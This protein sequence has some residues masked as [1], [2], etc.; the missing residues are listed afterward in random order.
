MPTVSPIAP[1]V[2]RVR[3]WRATF[4]AAVVPIVVLIV[5]LG[6]PAAPAG[7]VAAQAAAVGGVPRHEPLSPATV[8][9][10]GV[11]AP[12][13]PQRDARRWRVS[14]DVEYGSAV[15]RNLNW[16]DAYLLDAELA[17]VQVRVRRELGARA[18]VEAQ[19]G[20]Q[21]AFAGVSDAFFEQYHD[22][23]GWVM[24]ER[25]TRPRNVYADRLLMRDLTIDRDAESA[26]MRATDVRLAAGR[27]HGADA[28]TIVTVTLPTAPGD[29]PL[30]RGVP[31]VG[32]MHAR[33]VAIGERA[34][35]QGTAGI[36]WAPRGGA[37]RSVQ[38]TL[39]PMAAVGVR[40]RVVGAHGV[41]ASLFVH[42]A[43]YHRTGFPE[44]DD[45]EISLDFGYVWRSRAGREW[46][47]GLTEDTRRRD[48]GIDLVL[49]IA[50]E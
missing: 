50:V 29:A 7:S 15:E 14:A 23:I 21:G 36:G 24:E 48:P 2:P 47:L 16:P 4:R 41:Y 8:A 17:R 28:Q 6:A 1:P 46:R 42:D 32:A 27:M 11:Y 12:S 40:T 33:R 38:R 30:G 19:A 9:R 10:S 43:P 35:V 5:A 26:G 25:D 22:V 49:K 3:R 20:A 45:A 39:T 31:T 13:F 34:V 37:L 44:L 18:F